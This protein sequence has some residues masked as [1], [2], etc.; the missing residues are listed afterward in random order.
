MRLRMFGR[1]RNLVPER[2]IEPPAAI[3]TSEALRRWLGRDHPAL[4][5]PKVR[6]ALDDRLASGDEAIG[7]AREIAFLPP[8]SGG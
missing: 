7:T 5:D 8:V 4:L 3:T 2:D 6:I 1:L